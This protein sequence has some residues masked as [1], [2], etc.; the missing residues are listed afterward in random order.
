VGAPRLA[1]FRQMRIRR[2]TGQGH[3]SL[4]VCCAGSQGPLWTVADSREFKLQ[5][6]R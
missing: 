6:A 2:E 4:P 3:L 5:L 1:L